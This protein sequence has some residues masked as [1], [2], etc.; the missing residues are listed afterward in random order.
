MGAGRESEKGNSEDS[1][2]RKEYA[3]KRQENQH[4]NV[5][6]GLRPGAGH[7]GTRRHPLS[8]AGIQYH[9]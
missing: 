9:S 5:V 4:S 8:D 6:E 1:E 3:T 7:R 2:V